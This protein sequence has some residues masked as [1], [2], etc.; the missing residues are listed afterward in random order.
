MINLRVA[1]DPNELLATATFEEGTLQVRNAT[2][3]GNAVPGFAM[4]NARLPVNPFGGAPPPASP[5]WI[6]TWIM[7]YECWID[8]GLVGTPPPD[9]T[10][11]STVAILRFTSPERFEGTESFTVMLP[12][13]APTVVTADLVGRIIFGTKMPGAIG[14]SLRSS[15]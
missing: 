4:R 8:P 13:G 7:N 6:G 14:K 15:Q 3:N 1:E 12:S 2:L 11:T 9:E 5:S 10:G